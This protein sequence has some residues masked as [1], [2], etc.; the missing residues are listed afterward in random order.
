MRNLGA[1][2]TIA[3]YFVTIKRQQIL[4]G[5]LEV[6]AS[7]QCCHFWCFNTRSTFFRDI[8]SM[9]CF[10]D[11]SDVD[12]AVVFVFH[13]S[14][15]FSLGRIQVGY[16][17]LK[18]LSSISQ[19]NSCFFTCFQTH[20]RNFVVKCGGTAW[21]E[22][23]TVLGSMSEVTFYIYRLPILFLRFVL[24]LQMIYIFIY[25]NLLLDTVL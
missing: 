25:L 20:G 11:K 8:Y 9:W 19:L 12:C 24:S 21:C 15:L 10:C 7:V 17:I 1:E 5:S 14:S 23:N 18:F 16:T 13:I 4:K 3:L 2:S 22:T 6:T